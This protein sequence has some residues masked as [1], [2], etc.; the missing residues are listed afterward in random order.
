M[1]Y[2]KRKKCKHKQ[3][4]VGHFL[5]HVLLQW[6]NSFLLTLTLSTLWRC[7]SCLPMSLWLLLFTPYSSP[8]LHMYTSITSL[9]MCSLGHGFTCNQR[10]ENMFQRFKNRTFLTTFFKSAGFICLKAKQSLCRNMLVFTSY[11]PSIDSIQFIDLTHEGWKVHQPWKHHNSPELR[12]KRL[13]LLVLIIFTEFFNSHHIVELQLRKIST[14]FSQE[15]CGPQNFSLH[16][17]LSMG[18][19]TEIIKNNL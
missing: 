15:K 3:E 10:H 2:D 4:I 12:A 9:F 16:W 17:L 11:Y 18:P 6:L 14:S 19:S 1:D 5:N 8:D 7:T 13:N